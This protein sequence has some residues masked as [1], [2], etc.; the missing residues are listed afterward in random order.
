MP[1]I[2]T[3]GD[4]LPQGTEGESA[5]AIDYLLNAG[6]YFSASGPVTNPGNNTSG[7]SVRCIRDAY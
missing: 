5:D 2:M 3:T 1:Y 4:F 6:A 7:T